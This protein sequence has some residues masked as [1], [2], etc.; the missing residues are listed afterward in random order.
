MPEDEIPQ[1]QPTTWLLY[2]I[3]LFIVVPILFSAGYVI[4]GHILEA[5]SY[6]Y[7]RCEIYQPNETSPTILA[8]ANRHFCDFNG[9]AWYFNQT[10]FSSIWN[11]T[12][13]NLWS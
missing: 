9:T 7:E 3:T 13:T 5:S 2:L 6:S 1:T 10:R 4:G 8:E 12:Y 11:Q